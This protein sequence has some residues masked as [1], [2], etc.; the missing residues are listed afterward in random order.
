MYVCVCDLPVG[1]G[2]DKIRWLFI[3]EEVPF[4]VAV[5]VSQSSSRQ[6]PHYSDVCGGLSVEPTNRS[7]KPSLFSITESIRSSYL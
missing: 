7:R 6:S 1:S 4:R 3:S 5:A 2:V